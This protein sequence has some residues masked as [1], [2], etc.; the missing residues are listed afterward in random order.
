MDALE[1]AHELLKRKRSPILPHRHDL[2]IEDEGISL[3]ISARD[4]G[5]FWNAP[6]HFG[7]APTPDAHQLAVFVD[8][9][10]RPIV[11][12]F[13]RR[14]ST[15]GFEDIVELLGKLGKHRQKR[16]EEC[17]IDPL[18]SRGSFRER[19][20]GDFSEAAKKKSSA[21]HHLGLP[22]RAPPRA[23]AQRFDLLQTTSGTKTGCQR[24]PTD[25]L[26]LSSSERCDLEHFAPL[27]PLRRPSRPKQNRDFHQTEKKLTTRRS[28]AIARATKK[29]GLKFLYRFPE[30]SKADALTTLLIVV[31]V[32]P[33]YS[34]S[35]KTTKPF[36]LSRLRRRN[37][38]G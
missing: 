35:H 12:K 15:V 19:H 37:V 28:G 1:A 38:I 36:Y 7:K 22:T 4:L 18:K 31:M 30:D 32:A 10:S 6:G 25:P 21:A 13:K 23:P 5:D 14:F 33:R 26:A 9:N 11:L 34:T 8:L 27:R 2:P 24:E 16:H 3:K 20:R 17:D 29:G